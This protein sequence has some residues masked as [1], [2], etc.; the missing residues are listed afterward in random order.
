VPHSD[1]EV[2]VA[3]S[4]YRALNQ[5]S[6]LAWLERALGGSD[7]DR[8]YAVATVRALCRPSDIPTS[9]GSE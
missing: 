8:R 3:T 5:A 7:R 1:R 4:L 9:A 2:A 6:A